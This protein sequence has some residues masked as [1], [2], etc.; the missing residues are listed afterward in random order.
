VHIDRVYIPETQP[1]VQVREVRLQGPDL[2]Q[3]IIVNR[4]FVGLE[5]NG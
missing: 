2:D 1:R 5:E 4:I 3:V